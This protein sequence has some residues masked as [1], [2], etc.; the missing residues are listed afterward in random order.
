MLGVADRFIQEASSPTA[1]NLY[2]GERQLLRFP[3]LPNAK[4]AGKDAFHPRALM[5]PQSRT[6][7]ILGE[8]FQ[9]LGGRVEWNTELVEHSQSHDGVTAALR[10][11]DGSEE[12]WTGR[13]LVSCEGAHSKCGGKRGF[14]ARHIPC[15]FSWP[16][17]R[18]SVVRKEMRTI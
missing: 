6:E 11:L 3:F 18:L 14:R 16:T 10:R 17:S 15:S 4:V 8:F 2:V 13:W 9:E 12:Q 5:I 7:T 1:V